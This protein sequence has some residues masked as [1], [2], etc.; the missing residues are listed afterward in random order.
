MRVKERGGLGVGVFAGDVVVG[1][2][3]GERI[4]VDWARR[5]DLW[6]DLFG[7]GLWVLVDESVAGDGG[8]CE[9]NRGSPV[10]ACGECG[11]GGESSCGESG[12]DFE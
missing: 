2:E 10:G 6:N 8:D 1:A 5:D 3:G 9:W 12:E 7:S 4:W 11:I